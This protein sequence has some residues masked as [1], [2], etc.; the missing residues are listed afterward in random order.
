MTLSQASDNP[1]GD[2]IERMEPLLYT[3]FEQVSHQAAFPRGLESFDF[4][5]GTFE[6]S[7]DERF[8][9]EQVLIPAGLAQR[10]T[11]STTKED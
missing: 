9:L 2:T 6:P 11:T 10:G 5:P 8:V 4:V 1:S 7:E 3:V